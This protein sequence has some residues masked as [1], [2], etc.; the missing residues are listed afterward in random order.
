[1]RW[2]SS[3]TRSGAFQSGST[4]SAPVHWPKH[5]Q[6]QQQAYHAPQP[7]QYRPAAQKR[8]LSQ[9]EEEEEDGY[10]NNPS[11]QFGFDVKDDEYTNYQNRKE[12]RDGG[13]IMGSYSV[14]DSDGFI[15]TVKYTAHPKD[16][17]KAE[18][19]REPTDIVIKM[20]EQIKREQDLES[21]RQGQS[22]YKYQEA[23]QPQQGGGAARYRL[24][25]LPENVRAQYQQ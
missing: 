14:V 21:R 8:P 1:M 3:W 23:P 6:L 9:S 11:Y 7:Q 24:P 25:N 18:V 5:F 2:D 16:G 17:F 10:D 4:R 12:S 15:R 13:I 20:P 22:A 19:I